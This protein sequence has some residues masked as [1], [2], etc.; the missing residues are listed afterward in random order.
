MEYRELQIGNDTYKL[1]LTTRYAI[2]L[3]KALGKN[4]IQVFINMSNGDLPKFEDIANILH[5][6]LLSYHRITIDE[7]YGLI[8]KYQE[9]KHSIFEL[10]EVFIGVFQDAGFLG[11]ESEETDSKN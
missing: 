2:Q 7:V 4:P 1:R 5:S 3:E 10:I 9:D 8:D 6:C 11:K